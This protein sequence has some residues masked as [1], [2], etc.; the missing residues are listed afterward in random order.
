MSGGAKGL[1]VPCDIDAPIELREIASF[2]D[3]QSMV[4]ELVIPVDIEPADVTI[5][6]DAHDR[7]K[8]LPPNA[9]A[10]FLRWYW[11][12]SSQVLP[13]FHG[14]V[15]LTGLTDHRFGVADV[16]ADLR[17]E[18]LYG[19]PYQVEVSVNDGWHRLDTVYRDYS[20]AALWA[21]LTLNRTP[22]ATGARMVPARTGA[23][24][25]GEQAA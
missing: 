15:L 20:D 18:I 3:I 14:D 17:I 11:D 6:V 4:A 24:L 16:P 8:S 13:A 25:Q 5:F 12:P 21:V 23:N 7:Y 2:S 9:R 22:G 19:G 10:S 1:L